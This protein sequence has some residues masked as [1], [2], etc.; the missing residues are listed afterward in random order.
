MDINTDTLTLDERELYVLHLALRNW[1]GWDN[2]IHD[3]ISDDLE[4]VRSTL[5]TRVEALNEPFLGDTHAQHARA[6]LPD[7][8]RTARLVRAA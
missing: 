7:L 2:V 1:D 4:A 6:S 3:T 5:T 8:R